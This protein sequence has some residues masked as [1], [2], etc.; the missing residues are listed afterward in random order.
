LAKRTAPVAGLDSI[1]VLLPSF[2][3]QAALIRAAFDLFGPAQIPKKEAPLR[4]ASFLGASEQSKFE[5]LLSIAVYIN[6]RFQ[7][8]HKNTP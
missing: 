4:G 5:P 3:Q 7:F 6:Y 1:N 8:C 2:R